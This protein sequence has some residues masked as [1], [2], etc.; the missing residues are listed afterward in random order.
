VLHIV[1]Y[2]HICHMLYYLIF[3]MKFYFACRD[4]YHWKHKDYYFSNRFDGF[5]TR[6]LV[7]SLLKLLILWFFLPVNVS[8]I[9]V[10]PLN[11]GNK[12]LDTCMHTHKHTHIQM[13]IHAAER[14]ALVALEIN[15]QNR[16]NLLLMVSLGRSSVLL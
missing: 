7:M 1:N 11:K 5:H 2:W 15:Y 4:K 3:N 13:Y 8:H 14:L 12:H 10:K 6:I 9:L 16:S